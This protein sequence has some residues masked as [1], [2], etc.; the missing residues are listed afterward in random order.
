MCEQLDEIKGIL[1]ETAEMS[2]KNKAEF[3]KYRKETEA[4][5]RK[6]KAEFEKYRKETEAID[7]KNKA[8][9][10][11]YRKETEAINRKNKAEIDKLKK[12]KES[13]FKRI[14]MF[15]GDDAEATFEQATKDGLVV[16]G[17]E[18]IQNTTNYIVYDE[19]KKKKAEIDILM[20]NGKYILLIET[21]HNLPKY[22]KELKRIE[23]LDADFDKKIAM[24]KKYDAAFLKN[25]M[26]LKAFATRNLAEKFHK[27]YLD[28]DYLLLVMQNNEPK[29]IAPKPEPV[30]FEDYDFPF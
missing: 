29:V 26:I 30:S 4:I 8:E 1:K 5:D 12:E 17:R 23:E 27:L 25:K 14:G 19:N 2:K 20:T 11:K 18:F 21:K 3:E 6:N 7:R 28:K 9:F 22:N 13:E 24:I 16:E 10:E 15:W